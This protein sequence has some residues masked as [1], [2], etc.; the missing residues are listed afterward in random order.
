MTEAWLM[1]SR[2]SEPAVA[3]FPGAKVRITVGYPRFKLRYSIDA[4]IRELAP[5]GLMRNDLSP[6]DFER[7]YRARLDGFGV[8]HIVGVLEQARALTPSGR[9]VA[10][11]FEPIGKPCHR[12]TLAVW[13]KERAGLFVP[14]LNPL[15]SY[16]PQTQG[17]ES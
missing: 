13:L 4:T 1:T 17:T 2:Y 14:E 8:D 7:L 6:E 16:P 15:D 11:C 12:R 9:A 3:H 5:H 10:L